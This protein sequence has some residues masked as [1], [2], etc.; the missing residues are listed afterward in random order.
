[1]K[2]LLITLGVFVLQVVQPWGTGMVA[3]GTAPDGTHCVVEQSFNGWDAGGEWYTVRL[4]TR[5]PGKE[6]HD[7]YI[8]HEASRWG[9]CTISF[10]ED[11]TRI[12]TIGGDGK[13]RSF[14]LGGGS[15]SGPPPHLPEEMRDRP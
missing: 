9:S 5:Q 15:L 10:S 6:W 14:D 1:M 12:Y 3:S 8:D 7:H 4:Y 13:R 11:S 2:S